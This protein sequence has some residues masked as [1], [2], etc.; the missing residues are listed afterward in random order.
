MLST[1]QVLVEDLMYVSQVE[2]P[3]YGG[4]ADYKV[5]AVP[6]SRSKLAVGRPIGALTY[7]QKKTTARL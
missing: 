1:L 2:M 4:S 3:I 5:G 6:V 7:P